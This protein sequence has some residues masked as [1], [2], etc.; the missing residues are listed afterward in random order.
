MWV[1]GDAGGCLPPPQ[2]SWEV[3]ELGFAAGQAG[4]MLQLPP[5]VPG[6]PEDATAL[7]RPHDGHCYGHSDPFVP[8]AIALR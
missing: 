7:D 8:R 3:I 4:W 1:C 6:M 5:R 2:T